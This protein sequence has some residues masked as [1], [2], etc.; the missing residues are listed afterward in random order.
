MAWVDPFQR[1]CPKNRTFLEAAVVPHALAFCPHRNEEPSDTIFEPGDIVLSLWG[2][3]INELVFKNAL[4]GTRH[5]VAVGE[6]SF[7]DLYVDILSV[8]SSAPLS[9]GPLISHSS[10]M[11]SSSLLSEHSSGRKLHRS[12]RHLHCHYLQSHGHDHGSFYGHGRVHSEG[13]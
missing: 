5:T 11:C 1:G 12:H 13:I 6:F 3:G 9:P 7:V 4:D 2:L 8:S 10:S